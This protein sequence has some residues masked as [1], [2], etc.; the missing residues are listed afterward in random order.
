M[1][2]LED[3]AVGLIALAPGDAELVAERL[4]GL[5]DGRDADEVTAIQN[6]ATIRR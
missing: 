4:G 5:R 3:L 2:E 1:K 6:A